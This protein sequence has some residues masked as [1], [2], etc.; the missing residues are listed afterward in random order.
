MCLL[1]RGVNELAKARFLPLDSTKTHGY[2][3]VFFIK[4]LIQSYQFQPICGFSIFP[5]QK[6]HGYEVGVRW[7]LVD[8]PM[9]KK[10]PLFITISASRL[11]VEYTKNHAQMQINHL[12]KF[13]KFKPFTYIW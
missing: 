12:S 8:I 4:Y 9:C 10:F 7:V 3:S 2:L 13:G 5:T 6:R 11:I 1:F